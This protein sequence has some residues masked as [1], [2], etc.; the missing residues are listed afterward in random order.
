[1]H[2][3]DALLEPF[4]PRTLESIRA[5]F[6]ASWSELSQREPCADARLRNRLVG[7]IANLARS[8]VED[9]DE[10]TRQALHRLMTAR[11]G[12]V[13]PSGCSITAWPEAPHAADV[14]PMAPATRAALLW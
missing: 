12:G 5:A 4:E 3:Y 6:G 2:A 9:P 11:L 14:P 8:G 10:L 7:T 13:Q 1:M